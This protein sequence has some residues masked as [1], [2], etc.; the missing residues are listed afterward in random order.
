MYVRV[1]MHAARILYDTIRYEFILK[2]GALTIRIGFWAQN[3]IGNS[4]PMPTSSLCQCPAQTCIQLI[5]EILQAKPGV[6]PRA[7]DPGDVIWEFP[8]IGDPNIVP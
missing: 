1:C 3:R 2:K 7:Q 5:Q 8:K 6:S 4:C